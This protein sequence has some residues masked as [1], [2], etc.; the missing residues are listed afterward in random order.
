MLYLRHSRCPDVGK[1]RGPSTIF[2]VQAWPAMSSLPVHIRNG[3]TSQVQKA[4]L[5]PLSSSEL[6][7]VNYP[8]WHLW[9][10]KKEDVGM[11]SSLNS[12]WNKVNRKTM[13]YSSVVFVSCQIWVFTFKCSDLQSSSV[14]NFSFRLPPFLLHVEVFLIQSSIKWTIKL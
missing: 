10:E 5:S 9:N 13:W 12:L 6:D 1:G 14:L 8:Q 7:H 11:D 2:Q 3:I 4:S